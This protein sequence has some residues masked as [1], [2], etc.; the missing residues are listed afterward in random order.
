MKEIKDYHHR[1]PEII[2]KE[3]DKMEL[4]IRKKR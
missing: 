1:F 2:K 3:M 4:N